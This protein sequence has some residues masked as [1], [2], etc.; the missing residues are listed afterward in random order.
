[1]NSIGISI[2]GLHLSLEMHQMGDP[3]WKEVASIFS[4]FRLNGE[5][6]AQETLLVTHAKTGRRKGHWR[7]L[8]SLIQ[9]SLRVPL[10]RFPFASQEEREMRYLQ[11]RTLPFLHEERFRDF[12]GHAK[13]PEE[14]TLLPFARAVLGQNRNGHECILFLKAWCR[15]RLKVAA[16]YGSVYF[17]SAVGLAAVSGLLMHGVGIAD[18]GRGFLFLGLSGGGKSTVARLSR[19][20]EVVSD[21]GIIVSREGGAYHLVPTP[22]NQ[23]GEGP[24]VAAGQKVRLVAGLFLRKD[25]DV[26]IEKV[27]PLEACPLILRNHIHYFRYFP[28]DVAERTFLLAADLCKEVPFYRLHFREDP[29]FWPL[30]ERVLAENE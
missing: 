27:P 14:V 25:K 15:K 7:N 19:P 6:A 18:K 11:K 29:A 4:S 13:S 16:V 20:R 5:E 28:P 8:E 22:F 10:S 21:D 30:V 17:V 3:F 24:I 26:R 9:E 12:L 1:M 2:G 23:Y